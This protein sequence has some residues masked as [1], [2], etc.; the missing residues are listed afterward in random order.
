MTAAGTFSSTIHACHHG[1]N[2]ATSIPAAPAM[3]KPRNIIMR[4][5][6]TLG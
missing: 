1:M 4:V 2:H 3:V 6:L 5:L